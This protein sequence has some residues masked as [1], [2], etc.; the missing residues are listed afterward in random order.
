M[1]YNEEDFRRSANL[2]TMLLWLVFVVVLIL[3]FSVEALQGRRTWSY[4]GTFAIMCAGPYLVSVL[5]LK[6]K[7]MSTKWYKEALAIGYGVFFAFALWTSHSPLTFVYIFPFAS[8]LTLYKD[9]FLLFRCGILNTGLLIAIMI[10]ELLSGGSFAQV[11]SDYEIQLATTILCYFAYLLAVTHLINQ[12]KSMVGTLHKNLDHVVMTVERVKDASTSIVDGITVVRELAEENQLGADNVVDS[13]TQ[14]NDNNGILR[15]KTDSSLDMTKEINTQVVNVAGLIQE[16]VELTEGSMNH[17]KTSSGQL[18]DIVES[19]NIMAE[20]SEEVE[21]I[22]TEFKREFERVKQETGT[23]E[24]ITSQTNLLALNA[25]IEAARAGDAGKGFAV[26][27]DEIRNLSMGTQN[28]STRI[29]DALKN[30][31]DTSDKMTESMTKTLELI[32]ETIHKVTQVNHSVVQITE[33][34]IKLGENV[35]VIDTAM[36]DVEKSNQNLVDNMKQVCDVMEVMTNNITAA[37]TTTKTMRS[38]YEETTN[39]VNHIDHVV[40]K[41]IEEL[42]VGGFMSVEDVKPGMNLNI[43]E[44]DL[45]HGAKFIATVTEVSAQNILTDA[46]LKEDDQTELAPSK[47]QSYC[48]QIVVDNQL[49]HWNDVK[50]NKS[51]EGQYKIS[52]EGNPQVLNRRKYQRMPISNSCEITTNSSSKTIKGKMLNIS[53]NGFAFLAYEDDLLNARGNLIQIKI[54]DFPPLQ[55]KQIDGY[56]IRVTNNKGEYTVGCRMLEDNMK[57]AEFVNKNFL[58]KNR[59]DS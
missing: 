9:R 16:M 51:K 14:L 35:T 30:L 55:E 37:D 21:R 22:L 46:I 13:M 57:V 52:V 27:A 10:R 20:L 12:E 15:D 4:F 39:N 44:G 45:D 29:M 47:S 19:T 31:E 32:H 18:A 25:S 33:D 7:G 34:S 11:F 56:I 2:K 41:L 49:Y 42:G 54:K 8:M 28:S 1:E 26:V 23:I 53:A 38:K 17:A 36:R 59:Y 3:A 40:G 6:I 24:A 5:I 43:I 50:I 48:L 58:K